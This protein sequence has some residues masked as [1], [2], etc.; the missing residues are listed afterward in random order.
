MVRMLPL[1]LLVTATAAAAEPSTV[2]G[3]ANLIDGD[4]FAVGDTVIR[5]ADVDAPELA[6]T[7]EG[8]PAALRHCVRTWPML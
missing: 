1:A 4:T 7:C 2:T 8:G 3:H 5:L 6:Q